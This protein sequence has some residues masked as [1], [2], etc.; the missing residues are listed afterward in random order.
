MEKEGRLNGTLQCARCKQ[1]F[2]EDWWNS[3]GTSHED[4]CL[5]TAERAVVDDD[6]YYD[7][8]Y[9]PKEER[10]PSDAGM[11]DYYYET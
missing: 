9:A 7:E 6:N 4:D 3:N 5:T 8:D 1:W 2:P 10:D 11:E